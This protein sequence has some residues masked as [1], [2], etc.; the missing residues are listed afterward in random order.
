MLQKLVSRF[1]DF[2]R[3]AVALEISRAGNFAREIVAG[4]EVLEKAADSV[5][6]LVYE[7]NSS[8]LFS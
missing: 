5:K 2:G 1:V 3:G 7:V 4:V 8:F 6:I